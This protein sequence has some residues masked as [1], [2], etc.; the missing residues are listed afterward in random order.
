VDRTWL[1]FDMNNLAYRAYHSTGGLHHGPD[2][3]GTIF[4]LLR[5][6][7]YFEHRFQTSDFVFCFDKGPGLREQKY[8]WYK[9]T[10]RRKKATEGE[11]AGI[12]EMKVQ[13]DKMRTE[14]LGELGHSNVFWQGGY[15]ADDIM[16]GVCQALP[17]GDR[18]ILVTGDFDM[19]QLM[20]RRVAVFLPVPKTLMTA[21]E[22]KRIRYGLR[23]ENQVDIK[24]I[25]GCKTDDVPG[26]DG[27]GE[28]YAA[29]YLAG[30][31]KQKALKAQIDAFVQS[32]QYQDNLQVVRIPYPGCKTFRP[33][34]DGPPDGRAW[35][36]LCRRLGMDGLVESRTEARQPIRRLT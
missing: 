28:T 25:A 34:T 11:D 30:V 12:L 17:E 8:R 15:E 21:R 35:N 4:G 14:Y 18:A 33:T 20:S 2:P 24:A 6:L 3:V 27:A 10:R 31:L 23:P 16:A 22:F 13:L 29:Q 9:E 5:D 26:V 1:V 19:F 7:R 36:K 32:P